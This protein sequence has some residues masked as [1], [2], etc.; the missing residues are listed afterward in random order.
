MLSLSQ[1]F[2]QRYVALWASLTCAVGID[3]QKECAT[4]PTDPFQ[5]T[6]KCPK[7]SINTILAKH[8]SV[9]S[10]RIE[11]FSKDGFGLVS[12]LMCGFE[13]EV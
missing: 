13:M 3:A 2:T 12:Q 9:E 7:R 8:S 4:L 6:Q 1:G 5:Q 10:N 11:V